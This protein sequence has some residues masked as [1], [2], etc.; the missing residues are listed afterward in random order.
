MSQLTSSQFSKYINE[1]LSYLNSKDLKT[2]YN[3][4]VQINKLQ[5]TFPMGHWFYSIFLSFALLLYNT[6]MLSIHE[7]AFSNTEFCA[8]NDQLVIEASALRTCLPHKLTTY[9]YWSY[10][11]LS[12]S[13]EVGLAS[14][15]T[16]ASFDKWQILAAVSS[17][18][19]IVKGS[20][21]LGVPICN[22]H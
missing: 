11:R 8:P 9:Q 14:S 1:Q 20:A 12:V 21:R 19:E 22:K 2:P 16:S 4:N 17:T 13:A 6:F 15:V 7:C 18:E 5:G 10:L 3:T